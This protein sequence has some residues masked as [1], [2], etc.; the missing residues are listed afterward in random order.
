[1][2]RVVTAFTLA[3]LPILPAVAAELSCPDMATIVQVGSCPTEEEMRWGFSGY[4]SDNARMYD[5]D[6]NDICTSVEKYR[7]AKNVSLWEAGE[8]QG[9][10][11]CTKPVESLKTAKLE[12]LRSGKLNAI[13]RVVCSYQGGLQMVYRTRAQ[14]TV[15]GDKAVCADQ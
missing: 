5:K 12:E 15:Q 14:C 10:L 4:C 2:I 13:T 6:G 7:D 1:M 11:S 8:F 3:V 9:Y